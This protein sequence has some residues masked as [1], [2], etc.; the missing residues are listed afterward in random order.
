MALGVIREVDEQSSERCWKPLASYGSRLFQILIRQSPDARRPSRQRRIQFMKQV[1]PGCAWI[2][3][4]PQTSQ[5]L[6][7]Q[8]NSLGVGQQAVQTAREMSNVKGNRSDSRRSRVQ[9]EV[10]E[11]P[12]PLAQVFLRKLQRVQYG[13][14][15]RWNL[16]FCAAQPWLSSGHRISWGTN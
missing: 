5:L 15:H 2:E 1:I 6:L 11:I 9:L 14:S 10:G 12:A 8:A 16:E 3:F 4:R 7:A 13:T